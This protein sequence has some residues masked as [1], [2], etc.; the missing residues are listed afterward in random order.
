MKKLSNCRSDRK[1][2]HSCM[3]VTHSISVWC[4]RYVA[5]LKKNSNIQLC[6]YVCMYEC[7]GVDWKPM[8]QTKVCG[9]D[10]HP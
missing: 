3:E 6:M 5:I 10:I 2:Q 1:S 8:H 7:I 4:K 9:K